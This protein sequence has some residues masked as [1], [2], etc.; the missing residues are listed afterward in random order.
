M[1]ANKPQNKI[2]K[3]KNNINKNNNNKNLKESKRMETGRKWLT[4]SHTHTHKKETWPLHKLGAK[5]GKK[6]EKNE[7][8]QRW[9]PMPM[10]PVTQHILL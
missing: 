2:K 6:I 8:N 10:I 3:K 7:K 9:R 4:H 1:A 5:V